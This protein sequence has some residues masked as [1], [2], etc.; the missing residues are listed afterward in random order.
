MRRD[1]VE[2]PAILYK[3]FRHE[4]VQ[5]FDAVF[6]IVSGRTKVLVAAQTSVA[7]RVNAW[8]AD[9]PDD[10][11]ADA[12]P[13][14]IRSG[15]NNLRKRLVTEDEI[16]LSFRGRAINK[17]TKFTIGPADAYLKDAQ[18]NL[19]AGFDLR[20]NDVDKSNG[21]MLWKHCHGLHELN[22]PTTCGAATVVFIMIFPPPGEHLPRLTTKRVCVSMVTTYPLTFN[23]LGCQY[24]C[25]MHAAKRLPA[26]SCGARSFDGINN[27]GWSNHE[28]T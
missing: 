5:A 24:E 1:N 9:C 16:I 23:M 14:D 19:R 3:I 22:P 27:P 26:K 13:C 7:F 25:G 12:Q 11:I 28:S 10:K 4:P 8:E 15:L 18:L 21:T 2:I 6:Q 17:P 20:F